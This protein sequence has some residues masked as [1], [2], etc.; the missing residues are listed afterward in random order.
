MGPAAARAGT[1]PVANAGAAGADLRAHRT[2]ETAPGWVDTPFGRPANAARL[3]SSDALA[4]R[5]FRV[6]AGKIHMHFLVP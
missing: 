6:K 5:R 1:P 2:R 4:Q 3:I